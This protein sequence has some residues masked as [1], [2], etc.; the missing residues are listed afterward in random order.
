M[1]RITGNDERGNQ[2]S[3]SERGLPVDEAAARGDLVVSPRRACAFAAETASH[4]S[5]TTTHP[6]Q[7]TPLP[8][9]SSG[10]RWPPAKTAT[11]TS[12]TRPPSSAPLQAV[13]PT[14][15]SGMRHP[16]NAPTPTPSA[17]ASP[18]RQSRMPAASRVHQDVDEEQ[19]SI[20]GMD[21]LIAVCD[22]VAQ[23]DGVPGRLAKRRRL[24]SV[25]ADEVPPAA[26]ADRIGELAVVGHA[27]NTRSAETV[28]EVSGQHAGRA[29]RR[30]P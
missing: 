3:V 19:R 1:A 20:A 18:R 28:R 27:S 4:R 6:A 23:C 29:S 11:T 10:S 13:A 9:P 17:T 12:S 2:A 22:G 5:P 8:A 25:D 7:P 15:P 24:V 16:R 26:H 14:P 30:L 21:P